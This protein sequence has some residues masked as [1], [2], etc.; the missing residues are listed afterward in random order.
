MKKL[1]R[2]IYSEKSKTGRECSLLYVMWVGCGDEGAFTYETSRLRHDRQNDTK[3]IRE[4]T[5]RKVQKG[6]GGG[7]RAG[8]QYKSEGGGGGSGNRE[9][10]ERT[11]HTKQNE[12]CECDIGNPLTCATGSGARMPGGEVRGIER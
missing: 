7:V 8:D 10:E 6:V 4:A 1:H 2:S 9:Q 12:N 3:I 5:R 11:K